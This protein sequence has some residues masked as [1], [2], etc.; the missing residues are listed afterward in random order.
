MRDLD[1]F[2]EQ[3]LLVSNPN[4]LGS[5]LTN[6]IEQLQADGDSLVVRT[7]RKMMINNRK[8][9]LI[10]HRFRKGQTAQDML[11]TLGE[12]KGEI[13]ATTSNIGNSLVGR[14]HD[15]T[16]VLLGF[17]SL[18]EI[19]QNSVRKILRKMHTKVPVYIFG[20]DS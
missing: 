4:F 1:L 7:L 5:E 8:R 13:P 20:E 18:S 12:L 16:I 17:D 10:G 11:N 9:R 14:E 15:T 6:K 3:R 19:E 2:R